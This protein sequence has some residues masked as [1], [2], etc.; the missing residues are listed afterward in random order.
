MTHLIEQETRVEAWLEAADYLLNNDKEEHD[1][2]LDI[3]SPG[4]YYETESGVKESEVNARLNEHYRQNDM[5]PINA[6]AEWIFPGWLYANEGLSGVLDN[7]Q[8]QYAAVESETTWGTYADRLIHRTEKS[9][10]EEYS[11]LE[12]IISK[13]RD[14]KEGS[15]GVFH[16]VYEIG[17]HQ[18]QADIPLYDPDKDRNFVRGGPCLSHLSFKLNGGKVHLTALYRLHDYRFK[19]PGNLLGLARLQ[20]GVANEVEADLGKL[21]IHS[22][23]A[24]IVPSGIT[25]FRQIVNEFK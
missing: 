4:K 10:G 23:R 13:M 18:G 21:V 8:K 17:V 5:E 24:R 15:G 6:I 7:Y 2:I 16:S 12:K 3:V 20:V 11:P 25:E 9:S 19:V 1:L 14:Q 22:S